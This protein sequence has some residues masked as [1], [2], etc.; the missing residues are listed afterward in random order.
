MTARP[1]GAVRASRDHSPETVWATLAPLMAAR[2][3]MRVSRDGGR[4]YRARDERPVTETLPNQ[5]AALL[6]YDHTGRAPVVCLDLDASRGGTEAVDRDHDA[7]TRLLDRLGARWF[8]D[9]SPNGGRHL[10]VPFA[11]PVPFQE[12]RAFTL[13]LA[14]RTPTL[15]PL[16]MLNIQAGCIRPPGARH[17]SGGHQ[18]LDQ[19]PSTAADALHRPSS[20]QV[21]RRLLHETAATLPADL[22]VAQAPS[23]DVEE[24]LDALHGIHEPSLEFVR[25]A[26]TGDYPADRYR[27][28]SEARQA[29]LWA[30]AASG[31]TLA[32]V[33]RRLGDGT[34]PGLASF[35][36]RYSAS[37]R[38]SALARD[39]RGAITFE[40]RRRQRPTTPGRDEL[41]RSRTTSPQQTHGRG[42]AGAGRN[43]NRGVRVWLAAV[44]LLTRNLDPAVRTVL[45]ALGEAAAVTDSGIVEHGNRSLSIATGLD[46]STVGRIL[47]RLRE[48]PSDRRLV[49][50]L[51]EAEGVRANSYVLVVP[52]LLRPACEKK[53]WRRGRI[54]AIR[55][56]F[57]ELGLVAAFV[58][59]ALE[60]TDEARSGRHL[61]QSAGVGHS[62]AYD[63]LAS[64]A[65]W[66]L[67]EKSAAGGWQIGVA[68]PRRLAEQMGVDEQVAAQMARYR[69][70]R[71]AWWRYLGLVDVEQSP[72]QAAVALLD[73]WR[74]AP[75]PHPPATAEPDP[76]SPR[77]LRP[78]DDTDALLGLLERTL[79]A[80]VIG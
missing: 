29:V 9:T 55:P 59:A 23:A 60:Q 30:A 44:D 32:D 26:R 42:V 40:K 38:H 5:P 77:T 73:D 51:R 10:Y 22:D 43:V 15:D 7:L 12:A 41:V 31:W 19:S 49:D 14:A 3:R 17:R 39:W 46:Q 4:N 34:W 21:W 13:A 2:G 28:P 71:L 8:S 53:P 65:A 1:M 45:Y 54:H 52:A 67:A 78:H 25:I 35:Y 6:V 16:P 68:C 57:R 18:R 70:E 56:V 75:P 36:A 24:R 72:E 69:A 50:L 64:L 11:D 47:R 63:A 37:N 79:G 58:Y 66:G 74:R 27:S 20:A 80:R 48:E 62:A 33:A 76:V 61:A